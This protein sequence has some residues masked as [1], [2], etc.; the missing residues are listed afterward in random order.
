M[1]HAFAL[2]VFSEWWN[3]FLIQTMCSVKETRHGNVTLTIDVQ[4]KAV[5]EVLLSAC[6]TFAYICV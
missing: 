6:F 5:V 4:D 2:H 3:L 1:R